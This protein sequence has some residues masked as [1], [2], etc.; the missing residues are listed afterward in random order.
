MTYD[1]KDDVRSF[2]EQASCGEI[3]TEGADLGECFRNHAETRYRLEPY[4]RPFARF[5]EGA[6]QAVLEVGV[7]MGADHLEWA[8]SSPGRLAGIDITPRAIAWTRK[9]LETYGCTSELQEA[10][11]ERLPFRS[12]SF[13]IVYSWGVLHHSPDTAQALREAY[14]VLRPGGVLRA[15]IYH[16]PSVVGLMLWARYGVAA[17]QPGPEPYGHLRAASG[18]PWNQGLHDR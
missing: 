5:A 10:D 3:Y 1:L 7:G 4:I 17:G 6:H 14:R 12:E 8:K 2:W 18:I 9:R 13:D 16:R 15:M 11:A